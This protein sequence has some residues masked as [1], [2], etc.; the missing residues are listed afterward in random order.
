MPIQLRVFAEQIY[1]SG[2]GGRSCSY[3]METIMM[4]EAGE[5]PE[6]EFEGERVIRR[7]LASSENHDTSSATF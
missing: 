4:I 1:G 6:Y 2:P 5:D 3:M 7:P